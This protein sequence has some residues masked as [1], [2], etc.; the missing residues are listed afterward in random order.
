MPPSPVSVALSTP[1][2]IHA[3]HYWV[4]NFTAWPKDLLD[5]GHKYTTYTLEYSTY[6]LCRWNLIRSDSSIYL[7]AS[8]FSLAAF[9]AAR[10]ANEAFEKAN[11]FFARSIIKT[12]KE[13]NELSNETIDQ[14]IVATM[15]MASYDVCLGCVP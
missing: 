11:R 1:V 8:A 5:I 10:H 3:F 12:R 4:E 15:L 14:L 9:G 6:A 7:A 13:I 2:E